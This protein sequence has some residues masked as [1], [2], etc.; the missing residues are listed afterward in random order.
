MRQRAKLA[1]ALVHEPQLVLLDEPFN[2]LDPRQRGQMMTLLE[3]QA[4]SG[5][6]I[7]FSS[8]ILEEVEGI[9]SRVLVMVSG[10]LAASGDHRELRRL[11]TDRPHTI[12]LRSSNNRALASLLATHPSVIGLSLDDALLT[13]RVTDQAALS[14][15]LPV[16]AQRGAISLF[17]VRPADESLEH[18]FSY[19]VQR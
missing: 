17:E 9:A 7:V 4:E 16:A 2:G 5:T 6:A 8:H 3:S 15:A 19:L 18:V 14:R 10:R 12:H 1:A 11:M 13:V